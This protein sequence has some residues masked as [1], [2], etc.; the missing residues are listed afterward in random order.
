MPA[1]GHVRIMRTLARRFL[2]LGLFL[3]VSPILRAAP[4]A[5]AAFESLAKAFIE[6]YLRANPESAT[7]LGDHRFD[8][9][10]TDYSPTAIA[11]RVEMLRSYRANLSKI[12]E[13]AL[14]GAN[15]IDAK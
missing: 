7:Q 4:T 10:L 11:R 1:R 6:D 5:D 15:R 2:V 9:R 12:E 14:T 13:R 8:D 3:A